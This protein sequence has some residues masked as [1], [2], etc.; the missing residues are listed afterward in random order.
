MFKLALIAAGGA[1][2][3]VLRYLVGAMV[4]RI[5]V[6]VFPWG[7]L[8]VNLSGAFIIGILWELAENSVIFPSLRLFLFIGL[9]GAYTTFSTYS[10]ECLNLIRDGEYSRAVM[11]IFLSNVA[12]ISVVFGGI[13]VSRLI[14]QS[15][16]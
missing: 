12:G 11:N 5:V 15:F 7:T 8:V 4:S 2:G 10:L 16:K 9:L 14:I 3:A 6:D 1:M 13:I